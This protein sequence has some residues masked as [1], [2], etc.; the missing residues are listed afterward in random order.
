MKLAIVLRGIF[1]I[2]LR[3][4][5]NIPDNNLKSLYTDYRV[6]LPS[7][8]ENLLEQLQSVFEKIDIYIVTY[9]NDLLYQINLDFNVKDRIIYD[10]N[11]IFE[12][13]TM[14][15]LADMMIDGFNLF[16]KNNINNEYTHILLTRPDLYYY[17]KFDLSKVDLDKVNFGWTHDGNHNCDNFILSPSIKV[18]SLISS[19]NDKF[20]HIMQRFFNSDEI[21]FISRPISSVGEQVQPDFYV[22][23]RNIDK[24]KRGEF[25]IN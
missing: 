16:K 9:D 10:R 5:S 8:R 1:Y 25:I 19:L 7:F 18:D 20:S 12:T 15:K 4:N 24:L 14:P 21:N 13:F 6:C 23:F 22:I 11:K 17:K 3:E 2:D